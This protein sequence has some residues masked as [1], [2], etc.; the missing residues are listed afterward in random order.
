MKTQY[1]YAEKQTVF[2]QNGCKLLGR[3]QR[4]TCY[5]ILSSSLTT[6]VW[7]CSPVILAA[8]TAILIE[9][10]MSIK[11]MFVTIAFLCNDCHNF[12]FSEA[13]V[14]LASYAV[15]AKYGDYDENTYQ[16]SIQFHIQIFP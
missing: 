8:L 10:P 1:T 5:E 16:V 14:L 12:N 7:N 6:S 11:S 13:S 2:R 15:Q 4:T 9:F 3:S